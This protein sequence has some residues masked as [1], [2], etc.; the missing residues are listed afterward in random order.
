MPA[1][2]SVPSPL[3]IARNMIS[4]GSD[5]AVNHTKTHG[6]KMVPITALL[7]STAVGYTYNQC[8]TQYRRYVLSGLL[9]KSV[10][11]H[12]RVRVA[13][14]PRSASHAVL[15]TRLQLQQYEYTYRSARKCLGLYSFLNN[16]YTVIIFPSRGAPGNMYEPCSTR[17]R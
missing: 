15:L 13:V 12:S 11:V 14:R 6:T 2:L 7:R 16:L 10:P 3:R 8:G 17:Y 4:N 1:V 5:R 9:R